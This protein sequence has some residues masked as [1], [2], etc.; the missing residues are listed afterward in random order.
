MSPWVLVVVT[1]FGWCKKRVEITRTRWYE[2]TQSGRVTVRNMVEGWCAI[3]VENG[4]FFDRS[5]GMPKSRTGCPKIDICD[6][7]RPEDWYKLCSIIWNI[8]PKTYLRKQRSEGFVP[9]GLSVWNT[10]RWENCCQ[11]L[12]PPGALISGYRTQTGGQVLHQKNTAI[13]LF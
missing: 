5:K 7:L 13:L 9:K 4:Q 12:A 8:F 1:P 6:G 11:S 3:S 2:L 10:L